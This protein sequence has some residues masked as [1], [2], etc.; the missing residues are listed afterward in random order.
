MAG[1]IKLSLNEMIIKCLG[2]LALVLIHIYRVCRITCAKIFKICECH[3]A[4][5]N[6]DNVVCHCLE[7]VGTIFN[8]LAF[9]GCLMH[10]PGLSF[11]L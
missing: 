7:Q 2:S 3:I 5:Q 9:L 10:F 8:A 4:G 1:E 11:Y 6:Q